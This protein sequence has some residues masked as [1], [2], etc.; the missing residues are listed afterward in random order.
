MHEQIDQNKEQAYYQNKEYISLM[1]KSE[2]HVRYSS[3]K[4]CMYTRW[5][6]GQTMNQSSYYFTSIPD[7]FFPTQSI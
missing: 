5:E 6:I 7:L 4:N 3:G 1:T 2:I